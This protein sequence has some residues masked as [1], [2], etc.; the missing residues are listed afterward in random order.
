[1]EVEHKVLN[2]G[3]VGPRDFQAESG[4]SALP[5]GSAGMRHLS[6]HLGLFLSEGVFP[7]SYLSRATDLQ[8][9][10]W[11]WVGEPGRTEDPDV[12]VHFI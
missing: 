7:R 6:C 1:M 11:G 12:S 9:R 3:A 2:A 10:G 4:V 5:A 8:G